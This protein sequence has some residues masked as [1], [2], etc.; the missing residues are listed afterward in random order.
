[1][2]ICCKIAP[3]RP[4]IVTSGALRCGDHVFFLHRGQIE[5]CAPHASPSPPCLPLPQ[6][7]NEPLASTDP[8]LFDIIEHE[9]ARQRSNLLLIASENFASRSVFDALGSVMSNK[10]SEGYPG[11]RCVW[12]GVEG[13]R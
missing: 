13:K 10:Y 2:S 5:G 8:E 7:L 4:P 11:A 1:M 3:P 12:R 9:K 6:A